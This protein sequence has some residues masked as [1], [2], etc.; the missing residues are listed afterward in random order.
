MSETDEE[1]FDLNVQLKLL[2]KEKEQ[3]MMEY[4]NKIKFIEHKKTNYYWNVKKLQF[5][6]A[7]KIGS[8]NSVYIKPL[9]QLIVQYLMAYDFTIMILDD[10]DVQV[11]RITFNDLD[12]PLFNTKLSNIC[13]IPK[14]LYYCI[15][16]LIHGVTAFMTLVVSIENNFYRLINFEQ[17]N[18]LDNDT[19]YH[20]NFGSSTITQNSHDNNSYD[21]FFRLVK[22]YLE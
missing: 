14:S 4:E 10:N 15:E 21:I 16:H 5:Y 9:L 20:P 19:Y 6:D 7:I 17:F 12:F 22:N 1:L 3:M 11:Q 2:K 18:K 13:G 8:N